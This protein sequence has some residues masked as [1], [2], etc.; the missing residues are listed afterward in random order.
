M[1]GGTGA[2]VACQISRPLSQWDTAAK[3]VSTTEMGTAKCRC[4]RIVL[5]TRAVSRK[6]GF[7]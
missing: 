1:L 7:I 3:L 2:F 4:C 6:T 5:D